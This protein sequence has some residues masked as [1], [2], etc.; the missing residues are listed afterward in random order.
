ML[1]AV[2]I[3]LTRLFTGVVARSQGARF[4]SPQQTIYYANHTSHLDALVIW[5]VLPRNHRRHTRAAAAHDYW[6]RSTCRRYLAEKVFHAVP[7]MRQ[8]TPGTDPLQALRT[9]LAGGDSLI[10]FPEGTRGTG[11]AIQPFRKGLYH[12]ALARPQAQLV[13][14]YIDNLNR[15][16]PKGEFLPVPIICSLT[17]GSA[18]TLADGEN[19]DAFLLRAQTALEALTHHDVA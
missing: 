8:C 1:E 2:L 6:W 18:L 13:P 16:L 4:D 9:A 14:V 7:V 10:F 12:L 17:F 19:R 5:S 3:G 11:G 15:V